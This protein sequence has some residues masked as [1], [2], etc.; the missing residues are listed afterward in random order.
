[1]AIKITITNFDF[2][3]RKLFYDSNPSEQDESCGKQ[4]HTSSSTLTKRSISSKMDKSWLILG[5][6]SLETTH[7][8][9]LKFS[10]NVRV[11][12]LHSKYFQFIHTLSVLL[13]TIKNQVTMKY[14]Y[15][16]IFKTVNITLCKYFLPL[17]ISWSQTGQYT[18]RTDRH[19]LKVPCGHPD[20]EDY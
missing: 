6:Y 19:I 1:M 13:K 8:I 18:N 9:Y 14:F 3:S 11:M 10:V 12:I 15:I 2:A 4:L 17:K 7:R 16:Q 5:V 20:K